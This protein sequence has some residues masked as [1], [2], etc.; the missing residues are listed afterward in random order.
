MKRFVLV[1]LLLAGLAGCRSAGE[2]S[3]SVL[4]GGTVI[5]DRHDAYVVK[6]L[7][8]VEEMQA[9]GQSRRVRAV[10]ATAA[11]RETVPVAGIRTD[12]TEVCDRHDAF[13]NADPDLPEFDKSVF[14]QSTMLFRGLLEE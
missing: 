12:A 8:G 10:L 1:A 4:A 9:L 6:H 11:T 14:L 13:V 3:G 5:L 7:D 2:T